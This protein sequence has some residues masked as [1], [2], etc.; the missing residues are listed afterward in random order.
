MN[1]W[2]TTH[3]PPRENEEN[4]W[5]QGI[6][7]QDGKEKY[8]KDIKAGDMLVIYESKTGRIE[9]RRLANGRILKIPCK[10][11]KQGVIIIAKITSELYAYPNKPKEEYTNNTSA[12]WRWHAQAE[13]VTSSGFLPKENVNRIFGHSAKNNFRGFGKGKCRLMMM[14]REQFGQILTEYKSAT[15]LNIKASPSP[16]SKNKNKRFNVPE[17]KEHRELKEYVASDPENILNEKGLSTIKIEYEFPT[18]DRADIIMHDKFGRIIGVEIEREVND[19]EHQGPIQA[20]KY[21][22]MLEWMFDRN[23]NDSRSFLVA[24]KISTK[25][26]EKCKR[27]GIEY[28]EVFVPKGFE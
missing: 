11:G 2:F 17:S 21:R 8:G 24:N 27:Y 13:V 22:R 18:N 7:L 16:P 10:T 28:F 14:S 6:W 9:K 25:I 19:N 12:W 1:Y 15:L 20:I 4:K 26:K 5:G 3:W 23:L